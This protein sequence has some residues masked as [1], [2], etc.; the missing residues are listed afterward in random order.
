MIVG[1]PTPGLKL[2]LAPLWIFINVSVVE[3]SVHVNSGNSFQKC[4]KL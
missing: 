2:T 3:H 1:Y 4:E